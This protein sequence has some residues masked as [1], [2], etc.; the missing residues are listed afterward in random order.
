MVPRLPVPLGG[1][2]TDEDW[3]PVGR[4]S[5]PGG[6]DR[7]GYTRDGQAGDG[8]SGL[9]RELPSGGEHFGGRA[10]H[11][12]FQLGQLSFERGDALMDV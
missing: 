6:G 9:P 2:L 7:P 10:S 5:G 4:A 8:K 1:V 11:L 12:C 3:V